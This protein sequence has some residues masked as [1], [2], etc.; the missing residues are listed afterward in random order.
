MM[1][2]SPACLPALALVLTLALAAAAGGAVQAKEYNK[3]SF[4][5]PGQRAKLNNAIAIAFLDELNAVPNKSHAEKIAV[6]KDMVA[7]LDSAGGVTPEPP[8]GPEAGGKQD[9]MVTI[10]SRVKGP[11][12]IVDHN[13]EVDVLEDEVFWSMYLE[14]SMM[15]PV[16]LRAVFRP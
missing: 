4:I 6:V 2:S 12:S 8:T 13:G 10:V 16:V 1:S 14:A 7:G 9:M 5:P 11:G 3:R 15:E